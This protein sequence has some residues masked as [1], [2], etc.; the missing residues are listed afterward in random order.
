MCDRCVMQVTRRPAGPAV[1]GQVEGPLRLE[2][3]ESEARCSF[4]AK[5]VT[6]VDEWGCQWTV[7]RDP[8]GNEFCVAQTHEDPRL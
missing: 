1:E 3:P 8:E 2:P 5:R 6:D 7:M 4:G